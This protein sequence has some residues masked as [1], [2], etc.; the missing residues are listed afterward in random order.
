L[1][2]SREQKPLGTGGALRQAFEQYP[3]DAF[4]VLN[5][6]S[7]L[8]ADLSK[9]YLWHQNTH[10]AGSLLLTW[11]DNRARFG[12]VVVNSSGRISGFFEKCGISN[13]GYINAG[14]YLLSRELL[15]AL[16]TAIPLS[17]ERDVF[18]KWLERDLGGY[19]VTAPFIDI[20]TPQSLA[21]AQ[22]CINLGNQY[23]KRFV[24]LDRDGTVIVEKTHLSSPDQVELIPGAAQAIAKL[25]RSGLGIAIATNQSG[26]GRGFFG[27]K[28]VDA[29]HTRMLELLKLEGAAVDGIYVC[30]HTPEQACTCRK[31]RPGLLYRAAAELEFDSRKAFII[32][33]KASDIDAGRNSGAKTF[34]VQSGYGRKELGSGSA[35]ADFVVRDL[36]EAAEYIHAILR[37][38]PME[39]ETSG[40]VKDAEERLRIHLLGSISTKRR[41]LE[42]C[43][44]AILLA[45]SVITNR[46]QRGGKV[47]LCGN[48]GSAA[49]C[50]HIA[51]EMVSVLNQSFPRP[52]LPAIALTTDSSILTASANDFGYAGVFERQIQ[53]LGKPGDVLIGISTSG[54]SENVLRALAYASEHEI[55]TICLT[56]ATGGRMG[57]M[58]DVS[59]C[60]PSANV[61]HIQE[62]HISIGHILCDLVERTLFPTAVLSIKDA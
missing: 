40:L 25:R 59:I 13:S 43:E 42:E 14:I 20:G 48:G 17:I 54:N 32:G 50:Q 7:Y 2:Y 39:Y 21:E 51:G 29:V 10:R 11:V 41:V 23:G 4:L 9:F 8:R 49:D 56:G 1:H 19:Q 34:L 5:G 45:A 3:A 60:V 38:S 58:A 55:A 57:K 47:L 24:L 36:P 37:S 62:S 22:S 12:T 44:A 6:D 52:G 53:A 18:P 61:Q 27:I 35:A 33:D 30:P 26:V 31:P 16:P 28:E 15:S 46:L